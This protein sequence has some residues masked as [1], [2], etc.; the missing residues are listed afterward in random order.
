MREEIKHN[1]ICEAPICR[2]DPNP[3]YKNEVIWYAG[4]KICMKAPYEKFQI[5]QLEIN[6]EV[7]KGK[8]KHVD[9][10]YTAHELE[11]RSI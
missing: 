10:S 4:E 5:K 11:T 3:N 6:K 1:L 7:A 2:L 8:F 9:V